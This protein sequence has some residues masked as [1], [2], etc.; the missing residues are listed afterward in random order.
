MALPLGAGICFLDLLGARVFARGE[1]VLQTRFHHPLFFRV[2][3]PPLPIFTRTRMPTPAEL[4][5]G[6]ALHPIT[7]HSFYK[8]AYALFTDPTSYTPLFYFL[9]LKPALTVLIW[10]FL[11]CVVPLSIA[12]V[13]PA[14]AMLRLV[15]RLGV[16]QANI[17]VE[18]LCYP[19]VR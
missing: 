8:N 6:A 11:C 1:L 19:N 5:D 16:W 9:V 2:P 14:P 4:E 13:F 12:L 18:G 15:R 7:E 17:A 3:E 10:L